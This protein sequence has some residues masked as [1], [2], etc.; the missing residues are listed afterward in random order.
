MIGRWLASRARE[1]GAVSQREGQPA[2][3]AELRR[4][5]PLL[6]PEGPDGPFDQAALRALGRDYARAGRVMDELLADLDILCSVVG[7]G[8]SSRMIEASSVAWSDA[9]LGAMAAGS[10]LEASTGDDLESAQASAIEEVARRLAAFRSSVW[11][12]LAPSGRL[13][14][15]TCSSASAAARLVDELGRVAEEVRRLFPG[16]VVVAQPRRRRVSLP[17][18]TPRRP[19]RGACLASSGAPTW[20]RPRRRGHGPARADDDIAQRLFRSVG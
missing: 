13:L 12:E 9:F 19:T 10:T 17:P 7:I 8:A 6:W 20:S 18:R 4:Y 14:L 2:T 11:G 16:A 5:L 15:V 1:A 3:P